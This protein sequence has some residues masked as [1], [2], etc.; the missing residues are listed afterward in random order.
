M[1][2]IEKLKEEI[3]ET[4]GKITNQTFLE[5]LYRMVNSFTKKWGI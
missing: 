3:I 4:V 1:E 5:F 2:E